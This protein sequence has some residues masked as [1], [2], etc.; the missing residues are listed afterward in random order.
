MCSLAREIWWVYYQICPHSSRWTSRI[1]LTGIAY[2][3]LLHWELGLSQRISF[4]PH[5]NALTETLLCLIP[6]QENR[7][8][9]LSHP[10]QS[11]RASQWQQPNY[12][13]GGPR[14]KIHAISTLPPTDGCEPTN[15][16]QS[17]TLRRM[18]GLSFT[19][20]HK[21]TPF[22]YRSHCK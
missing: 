10:A 3:T 12:T 14:S 9:R 22:C 6:R 17:L 15:S 13:Q 7:G 16:P 20:T 11:H 2:F 4:N 21:H 19:H 18:R 1:I 8:R 5:Y